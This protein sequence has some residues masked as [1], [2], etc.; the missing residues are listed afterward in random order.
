MAEAAYIDFKIFC[1][2][3]T[4]FEITIYGIR[5]EHAKHCTTDAVYAGASFYHRT[6][7]NSTEYHGTL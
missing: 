2:D 3:P 5:G 6:P 4:G 1:Y 7:Q